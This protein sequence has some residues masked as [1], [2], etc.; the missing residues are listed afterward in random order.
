LELKRSAFKGY[1]NKYRVHGA[2]KGQTP[3]E[4][5]ESQGAGLKSYRWQEH[6]QGAYQTPIAA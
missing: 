1:Y 5:A 2:L 3:I 4:T 6:C